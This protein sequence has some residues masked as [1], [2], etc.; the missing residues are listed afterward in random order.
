[1]YTI[2]RIFETAKEKG[3]S[4]SFICNKLGKGRGY[5][6]D[7][8]KGKSSLTPEF[9]RIIA[10]VLGVSVD[11]L[12]GKEQKKEAVLSGSQSREE[13]ID[14]LMSLYAK[15]SSERKEKALLAVYREYVAQQEENQGGNH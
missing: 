8:R 12:L 9:V 6:H 5:L 7:V 3:I 10:D 15:L 13:K 2:D 4:I 14:E 11:Y 1:M